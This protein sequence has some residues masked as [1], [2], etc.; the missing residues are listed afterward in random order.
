[1]LEVVPASG[2]QRSLKL[3]RPFLVGL[4]EHPHLIGSQ[5]KVAEHRVERLTG[6]DCIEEPLPHVGGEPLL[7]SGSSATSL[8]V[9][10]RPLRQR[11]QW[12]P[13]C[14]P[15]FVLCAVSFTRARVAKSSLS[16]RDL[17]RPLDWPSQYAANVVPAR[18]SKATCVVADPVAFLVASITSSAITRPQLNGGRPDVRR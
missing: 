3:L 16:W 2:R 7:R 14:H 13:L 4:G 8:V 15:A 12:H 5:A 17:V 1:V 18:G 10:V 11:T 6:V 9:A